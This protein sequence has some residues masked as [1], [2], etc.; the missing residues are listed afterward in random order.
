[1][2]EVPGRDAGPLEAQQHHGG[3]AQEEP[4]GPRRGVQRS[5]TRTE[6][7]GGCAL[8]EVNFSNST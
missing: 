3:R 6:L 8:C 2:G 5:D 1:M 7:L 4:E